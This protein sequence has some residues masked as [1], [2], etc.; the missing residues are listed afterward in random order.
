VLSAMIGDGR[1]LAF[2]PDGA[3]LGRWGTLVNIGG[4]SYAVRNPAGGLRSLDFLPPGLRAAVGWLDEQ[5]GLL[6]LT[7]DRAGALAVASL[8]TDELTAE[9]P[10]D[11]ESDGGLRFTRLFRVDS[12]TV[13]CLYERGLV[14]VGDPGTVRWHCHHGDLSVRLLEVDEAAVWLERQWPPAVNGTRIGV[15]IGDGELVAG[16]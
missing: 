9:V 15:R 13:G 10:L 12:H 5:A 8:E 3:P 6:V 1:P 2:R 7:A 16:G 11:R 14:A 4:A